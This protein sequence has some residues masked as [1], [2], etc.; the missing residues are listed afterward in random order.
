VKK[1]E[2]LTAMLLNTYFFW[3]V[4]VCRLSGI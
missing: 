1:I 4:T 3:D 2:I